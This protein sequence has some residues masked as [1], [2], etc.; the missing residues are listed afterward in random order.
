MARTRLH[1][2]ASGPARTRF[3]ANRSVGVEEL[4]TELVQVTKKE[5][6]NP[7]AKTAELNPLTEGSLLAPLAKTADLAP[8]AK[9]VEL[10]PLAKSAE[11]DPLAKTEELNPLAKSAELNP[12]AK[13][14]ELNPLA[15]SA[16]L[17]I[18][19]PT[20]PLFPLARREDFKE[21]VLEN[22]PR[23]RQPFQ[24]EL[25]ELTPE[26]GE[27][28]GLC[29]RALNRVEDL[30]LDKDFNLERSNETL[31]GMSP[32]REMG[33]RTCLELLEAIGDTGQPSLADKFRDMLDYR[34][35][36]GD[37]QERHELFRRIQDL[38]LTIIQQLAGATGNPPPAASL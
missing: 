27:K 37:F 22:D 9:T 24:I 21:T 36:R 10:N 6:L 32:E 17:N 5:D 33:M 2:G 19:I 18:L 29:L 34:F 7:L 11:L 30:V 12:L 4:R 14:A 28:V 3:H 23:P 20:S 31:G 16:E 13:S 26:Q 25:P 15:K 8:L 1:S 35:A 38:R